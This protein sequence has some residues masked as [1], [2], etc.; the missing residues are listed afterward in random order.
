MKF[1]ILGSSGFIG[2]ELINLLKKNSIEFITPSRDYVFSKDINLGHAI[3]C[4]GLTADFRKKPMETIKAHV[5]KLI[6]CL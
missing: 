1:T 6:E 5:C 2:S 4:I 3:Y